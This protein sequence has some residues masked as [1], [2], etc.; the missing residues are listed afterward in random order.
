MKRKFS[1]LNSVVRLNIKLCVF[2]VFMFVF[3]IGI[4]PPLYDLFC[5]I[6]GLNG[7]TSQ[8]QY[9]ITKDD[10]GA[11]ALTDGTDE[12]STS[13]VDTTRTIKVQFIAANN[14]GM[15]W[16][17]RPE[18]ASVRVHPGKETA[19]NYFAH[20]PTDK[21]MV[22]QT[23]P[24]LVPYRAV[25]YFHK[26]ECFCFNRQSLDGGQSA[27]L[28]LSFIIDKDI[29]KD[30]NTITLSYTIFDVSEDKESE[31]SKELATANK[32]R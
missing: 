6:T 7:K 10:N 27:E 13:L 8:Q 14:E 18:I 20:N 3:A 31:S 9:I 22:A 23:I 11:G 17:F 21:H 19:I 4:M 24:S 1:K 16:E 12:N 29:P 32:P 30:V 2:V 15:P 25:D 28:G 5:E 26:T